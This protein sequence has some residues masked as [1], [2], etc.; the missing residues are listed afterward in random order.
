MASVEKLKD[1]SPDIL[2][3][4]KK[5]RLLRE[6]KGYNQS[7]MAEQLGITISGYSRIERLEVDI[8]MHKLINICEVFK[9]HVEDFINLNE[10]ELIAMLSSYRSDLTKTQL[11]AIAQ[12]E[13]IYNEQIFYLKDEIKFL[14]EQLS[15][16]YDALGK[17]LPRKKVPKGRIDNKKA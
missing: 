1:K 16:N 8:S 14:R 7:F 11:A 4:G 17:R 3:V 2:H 15:K 6:Y 10:I 5:L 9:I 12:L 13:K